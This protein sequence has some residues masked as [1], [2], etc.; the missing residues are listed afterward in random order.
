MCKVPVGDDLEWLK[1]VMT[2]VAA[3][4]TLRLHP[5]IVNYKHS[6]L[7]SDQIADFGPKVPCLNI[8]MEYANSGNLEE[9]VS[10]M[11]E[12]GGF[13]EAEIWTYFIDTLFG[14]V[15]S[16]DF[17]CIF[18]N[19]SLL[20][21]STCTPWASFTVISKRRISCSTETLMLQVVFNNVYNYNIYLNFCKLVTF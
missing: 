4:E 7:E 17:F 20:G 19:C 14:V 12:I 9:Y 10:E 15:R 13:S 21:R 11:A 1:I 3:L 2:E 6:W 18:W 16:F 8:L 5:N